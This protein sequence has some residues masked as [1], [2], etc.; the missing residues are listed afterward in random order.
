MTEN[1]TPRPDMHQVAIVGSGM[2]AVSMAV[3]LTGHGIGTTLLA[4]SEKSAQRAMQQY[5]QYF[6]DLVA[7]GL[8]TQQQ[9]NRCQTCLR[10]TRN[11]SDLSTAGLIIE[12]V[13]EQLDTKHDVYRQIEAVCPAGTIIASMTSGI[14][15]DSLAA[16][17]AHPERLIVAHPFMPPHLVPCVEV[18]R[19]LATSDETVD[20]TVRFLESVGRSVII[21][22]RSVDGFI[23][24]RLQYAMFREAVHLIELG[25]ATAADID[26]T[27]LTSIGPRYSSIGLFEHMENAGLDLVESIQRYLNPTLCNDHS[28]QASLSEHVAAGELGSKSG[29]GYLD[30]S[31]I[32]P[33]DLRERRSKPY[34]RFFNWKV[35]AVDGGPFSQDRPESTE[36]K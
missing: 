17:L 31:S 30:W 26:R 24:N 16:G 36:Q 2:I 35:P 13:Y 14:A 18:V 29:K 4:R 32:D 12:S 8:L 3:L 7:A 34:H 28:V 21:L 10:I 11:W 33:A 9:V 22:K 6:A 5:G 27:L 23:V 15:P 1:D 20:K 25:V 19:S